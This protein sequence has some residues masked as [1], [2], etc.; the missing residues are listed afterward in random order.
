MLEAA[1][2]VDAQGPS[3]VASDVV[4]SFLERARLS[5]ADL[6][7]ESIVNCEMAGAIARNRIRVA[8]LEDT[9]LVGADLTGARLDRATLRR[10]DLSG[11]RLGGVDLGAAI[12]EDCDLT[13][14]TGR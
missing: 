12:M 4:S 7:G 11:A 2:L 9:R 10:C 13:G 5:R 1:G 3:F 14:A 6:R 8:L